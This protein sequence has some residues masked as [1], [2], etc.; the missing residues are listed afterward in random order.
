MN[1]RTA[2]PLRITRREKTAPQV[3]ALI[4]QGVAPALAAL[5][6]ARGVTQM[7]AVQ[8]KL[9]NLPAPGLMKGMAAVVAR[10]SKAIDGN[11]RI[12]I[13]A[14]Y[15][16]DGATA[17]AVGLRGLRAMGA[18]VT[19]LVPNRF[20]FGYGL[21][22]EIVALAIKETAPQVLVTVDNGIA[23]IDG[24]AYA[25][26]QGVEVIV[27]DH[28]LPAAQLPDALI[29]NPNQPGCTFPTKALAGVGVMFYVLMALRAARGAKEVNLAQW[30]D[31]VALGTVADVVPLDEVNRTLVDQ[32]LKRIRSE[33]CCQGV[34]A[35]FR[36]ASKNIAQASSQDLGFIT[37][38]RINA[39]GR[40][41]DISLGIECLITDDTARADEI[42]GELDALNRK[43]RDIESGMREEALASI[44][45]LDVSAQFSVCLTNETWH[46]GVIGIVAGRIK[47]T[48]NRPTIVFAP[49]ISDD[50]LK[51]S[52][53][54]ITGFHLRDALDLVSKRAPTLIKK[55]GGH[56][57]A[58]GLS[59]HR[60]DF[61]AFA[62]AFETVSQELLSK[63]Q[64][65][66]VYATDG[67]Y[68]APQVVVADVHA[69]QQAVWGQGFPAPQFDEVVDV[70]EQK[71]VGVK[72]SK[73]RVTRN[74]A[75]PVTALLWN[76]IDPL[77][78]RIHVVYRWNVNT[79][80]GNESAE[81]M[82]EAWAAGDG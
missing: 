4:A 67:A 79:F 38:P 21:T 63:D 70:L 59:I 11:E 29:V 73:L 26:T 80:N 74:G 42:A 54:S 10:L 72:H 51:G 78:K 8:Y 6:A 56:A 65:E 68:A 43:R 1:A 24:A 5:Y 28:H 15:D 20:E 16:A 27:T 14:D 17:C 7:E 13:V 58:A 32:G 52:G 12:C 49:G 57:M 69:L 33:Q 46:Q 39:A 47:D 81:M 48:Y 75:H 30:L 71:I 22:P 62:S 77:P 53:R 40:L 25:R 23:S 50:E 60:Q 18:N 35:L 37:G 41:S 61:A 9:A 34:R 64:L 19:Y 76:H 31:L 36:V 55:F 3:D 66:R 44:K 45:K 2:T 82:I